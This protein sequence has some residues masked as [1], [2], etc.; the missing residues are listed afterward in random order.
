MIF[1][2]SAVFIVGYIIITL[3][4]YWKVNK[5]V[6]ATALAAILWAAI[7]LSGADH[8]LVEEAIHHLS[9]ETFSLIVF[10]LAAMTLVEI[11]VHYRFFDLLRVK[12]FALGLEDR[13]Q[14]ILIS[15]I[16]FF[17]SAIIDNLTTTIVMVQI[18]RRFFSGRNLLVAASAI[19]I[20]ANA[21]EPSHR[22]VM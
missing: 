10:L 20:S 5:S 11:L 17:L 4:Y 15:T 13:A 3:E 22:L 19:V 6:T 16:A 18:A 2:A 7:A 21:G 12:L 1:F 8:H 9:G 14:L